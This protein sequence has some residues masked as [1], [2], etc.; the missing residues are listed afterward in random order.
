MNN[1]LPSP[2]TFIPAVLIALIVLMLLMIS[3]ARADEIDDFLKNS[4][5]Q[6]SMS[7]SIINHFKNNKHYIEFTKYITENIRDDNHP[8]GFYI[9]TRE[10]YH[11]LYYQSNLI[12]RCE[13][14]KTIYKNPDFLFTFCDWIKNLSSR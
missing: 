14:E 12:M 13:D 4:E 8:V 7:V 9:R 1:P 5:A 3:L 11:E 2:K 10:V 6:Y